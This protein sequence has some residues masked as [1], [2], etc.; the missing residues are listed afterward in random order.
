MLRIG[1]LSFAHMHAHGYAGCLRQISNVEII[2]IA[3]EDKERGQK[4]A[5]EFGAEY[6]P[7]YRDLLEERVEAVIICSEN[8]RHKDMTVASAEAGKHI[9]CEKPIATTL[10]EARLMIDACK[11]NKVKLEIAF[12]CR[13]SPAVINVKKMIDKNL[14]GEILAIKA[15]NHGI[16]PGGWFIDKNKSGGG[17]VMDHTVH[18]VDLMRWMLKKE[19]VEVY[20]EVD[21]LFYDLNVDDCG[22]LT[23]ELEGGIFATLD[24]SWSRPNKAFPTWGDVTMEI[25]GTNGIISLDVFRQNLVLYNNKAVR[26]SYIPWGSN[27]GL[28]LTKDFIDCIVYDRTPSITGKDGQRALEVALGAYKSAEINQ[29]IK[30]ALD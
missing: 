23:L 5:R 6:Y 13:F 11:E 28:G 14:L 9:L 26:S 20:A 25:V 21:T 15:T 18:V 10:S 8:S 24:P 16:L 22:I 19:V 2:G 3:D 27:M 4:M 29:P 7:D 17:A 1:M 12:P 30:L